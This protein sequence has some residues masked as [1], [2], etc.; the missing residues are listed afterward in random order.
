[1]NKQLSTLI[2]IAFAATGVPVAA[3]EEDDP[4]KKERDANTVTLDAI[5]VANLGIETE[6]VLETD[7][8]STVFSLGRIEVIPSKRAVVSS[9]IE[10]RVVELLVQE[11]DEVESGQIVARVESRQPGDPPPVIALRAPLGGLVSESHVSLGEPIEPANDVLHIND[12]REV[13]AVASVPEDQAGR[14]EVGMLAY[15]N[16][17][18]LPGETFE[19]EMLRFGT[20]ADRAG[21]T[22]DAVFRLEN[23]EGKLRP[24]MRAEFSIVV[25]SREFVMAVPRS[26]LQGDPTNRF[27][28]VERIGLENAFVK[29]P[30]QIGARNDRHVEI[31]NGLFPG[32]EVVVKGA[33]ML[34]FAGSG[35]LSLKEALDAA[36]GHEHNED[37][38]EMTAEDRARKEAESGPAEEHSHGHGHGAGMLTYVFGATTAILLLLLLVGN[39]QRGGGD[40]A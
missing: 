31:I 40:D 32:D 39:F 27:V 33:Y 5:G 25:S 36:H 26:A 10:G 7:F 23:P 11:G 17:A 35:T 38:S 15:I 14:L 6:E 30:V 2:S 13:Y 37:G 1:M 21:G 18:A 19:G 20:S 16:V 24:G 34:A 29:S 12:L 28:Y 22:L 3:A 4:L 9:R 8:E